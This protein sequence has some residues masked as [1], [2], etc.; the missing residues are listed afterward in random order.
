MLFPVPRISRR[1]TLAIVLALVAGLLAAVVPPASAA[2]QPYVPYS[3]DSFFRSS[4]A[5]APIDAERTALFRRVMATHPDQADTPYP[6]LRGAGGNKWGTVYA[7]GSAGDP[8]W[9]LT[10][11]VPPA[12]SFLASTGFHAPA[13]LGDVL[14]GTSDS[15]FVV[16]DRASGLSV[17]AAKARLAGDHVIHVGAA[18][19]FWH[20]SNGLDGRNPR[21]DDERNFRSRGAIPDAMVIRRDLVEHAVTTGGDLGHVLHLFM[22]ETSSADGFTHPMVGAESDKH[23]FGAE[24]E[25]IALRPDLDVE[26]LPLSP[27]AKVVARTLQRH[28]AY[29]GDNSGSTTALKLEQESATHPVWDGALDEHSLAALSWDDFVV[30]EA[31]WQGRS[32]AAPPQAQDLRPTV[33]PRDTRLACPAS[34]VGAGFADVPD[35]SPFK[36]AVDCV[37]Q[38]QVA[39][40]T[41]PTTYTPAATVTREQMAGFIAR[42]I[43]RTGGHLP[44]NAPDA[45]RDDDGSTFSQDIDAL[46]AAGV[47]R[48]TGEQTFSPRADVSRA[49][50]AAL[51]VRAHDYR[52]S[53]AGMDGL[54]A[55]EDFFADDDH[56]ALQ[57][58]INAAARAGLAT[59]FTDGTF[60]PDQ[61]VRRDHMAAFLTRLLDLAVEKDLAVAA[62]SS[63]R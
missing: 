50:M 38:W 22:V 7:E 26:S 27:A 48:G 57:R 40:G 4:V 51:L 56:T 20:S 44:G 16:M 31:G 1:S 60:R 53:Q 52:A 25:R 61:P 10:G 9:R 55:V 43:R 46:A 28:G 24:G 35:T 63:P 14:T 5:G 49:Q 36:S 11:N 58:D 21:S 54:R 2:E 19:A 6:V 33:R 34:V 18:G 8:V 13:W 47:V 59:G 29:I 3:A 37:Q 45:F 12:V 32:T 42:V 23:G 15:P 39:N 41:S 30:V 17:W 62:A